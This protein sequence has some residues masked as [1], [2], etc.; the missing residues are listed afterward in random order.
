MA[1]SDEATALD[2]RFSPTAL[3]S[4][5]RR[6]IEEMIGQ[7]RANLIH[8][9]LPGLVES[10][11]PAPDFR[12]KW[13]ANFYPEFL[14]RT[15]SNAFVV[16]V[17]LASAGGLDSSLLS[18]AGM[19]LFGASDFEVLRAFSADELA[20]AS[21]NMTEV[22][23]ER[24]IYTEAPESVPRWRHLLTP[25]ET[26]AATRLPRPDVNG[27]PGMKSLKIRM[28]PMPE[29][30]ARD[31]ILL[32]QSAFPVNAHMMKV[33]AS[34]DDRLKHTYIVGRTG[35]GK[36]TLIQNMALQDIEAGRGVGVI[37]PH[38]DLI[39]AILERIPPHRA[40]DVVI[41]DP[42]DQERP[43]ALNILDVEGVFERNMVIADFLGLLQSMFDPNYQGFVGP[44]FENIVRQSMLAL[45]EVV[46]DA[47]LIDVVRVLTDKDYR[48]SIVKDVHD[49]LVLNYWNNVGKQ[50]DSF[51]WGSAKG[52]MLDW[53]TSKFGRF[54]DDNMMRYIIGQRR[55][56]IDFEGIMNNRQ[57]LL[58]DLS[59]G[60]IGPQNSKFLGLLLVPRLLIAAHR[61][62][63][64]RPDERDPFCLYVDEFQN[65]TTPS[66]VEMLS[67]ARKYGVALTMANQFTSQLEP[68]I[69]E[70]VFGNVGS[71]LVFQV[72]IKDALALSPELYPV[73]TDDIINLPNYYLFAKLLMD[74]QVIPPFPVHTLADTRPPNPE[75]ARSIRETSRLR[76]GR[77]MSLV[78][79]Q[80]EQRFKK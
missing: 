63:L 73:E 65:F 44:R 42:S 45:M 12:Q 2:I 26:L 66:F 16:Q 10:D 40:G 46:R 36:S 78:Q 60:K 39:E 41:F 77:N 22:A 59:K 57:I 33:R 25:E 3:F 7:E 31:G 80:I 79:M 43:V 47:T 49:P 17:Q 62:A 24:W 19:D 27:L 14:A 52:E 34:I 75:L 53:I 68:T 58:V 20:T 64:L 15:H 48:E 71:L 6:A 55:N 11:K 32:G 76:Y 50:L 35:S 28:M 38:G 69:R 1:E 61:R 13:I 5:E 8:E 21:R 37:D 72:G 23:L 4:W 29:S 9:A 30:F 74:T 18:L 70:A 54:V 67:E 56:T 51:G